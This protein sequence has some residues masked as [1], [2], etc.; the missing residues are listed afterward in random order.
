MYPVKACSMLRVSIALLAL[1]A[2]RAAAAEQNAEPKEATRGFSF[3]VYGDS[4]S[5][6]YL[7]GKSDQKEEAT[8]LMVDMFD[9]VLPEKV[10]AEVV[11]KDVKL[12]YDPATHE[13]VQVVM[14]FMTRSEVMTLTVDKGWVTEASVED[15]KLLPGVRRTMFRLP[16]GE[17]VAREIVKDVQSGR[18]KFILNTGDMV[19]WGK[20]GPT[21]S[22]N[23]YWKL[24]NEDVLKQLPAP[25]DQMR[26]SGLPGRVFPAVGNHEVWDDSD[27]EGLLS[28]FPYLKQ[29]GV[30]DKRLIYKFDFGGARFIFLYTGKYDYRSPSA[31]DATRP[32]YEGQMNELK[33]WLDEAKA[34]GIRKVFVSFHA[35]AFCPA[36][37]GP[38]PEAQ[39]PH[40]ILASYAKDLEIVVFNGHVHTTELYEVDGVKY[41][42]LG[43]GGAEQDP[44]LPGRTSIKVP[45]DYPP[46]LYWKGQPPKEEYN[47]VLVDVE[48]GQKTKFT[49]NR[50]RPWSAE[51]FATV[52]LFGSSK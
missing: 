6:M 30:S 17:W 5:M 32:A 4:R 43:G 25:D 50:F 15:V 27:V 7:P 20:Q 26:A 33:Q 35:P 40:K 45:A 3:A 9:L 44:I 19:W 28:A 34:A 52:E 48:P 41:L 18:V 14:P 23:P 29:F 11:K 16:G 38:I 49:L 21:P 39:N 37:M 31:W 1:V 47:Y 2:G 42:L 10:A 13:L 36:G 8:K 51:P 12:I 24:V 22:E 46:D